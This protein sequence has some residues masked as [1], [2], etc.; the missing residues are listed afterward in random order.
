M[1]RKFTI[2]LLTTLILLLLSSTCYFWYKY[3]DKSVSMSYLESS[4]DR[5]KLDIETSSQ[6]FEL[7]EL[8]YD[9]VK[10]QVQNMS[11]QYSISENDIYLHYLHFHFESGVLTNVEY[12][13]LG[14]FDTE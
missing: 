11:S 10:N 1:N 6:I 12:N 13:E 8:S 2:L 3:V 7:K 5:C 4:F 14:N 9:N